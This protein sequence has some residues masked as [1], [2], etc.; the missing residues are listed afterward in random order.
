MKFGTEVRLIQPVI[1]GVVIQRRIVGDEMELL[2]EYTDASE[3]VHQRWF[4]ENDLE[5]I[6]TEEDGQ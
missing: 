1:Q 3:Q 6:K 2:V 5:E 4:K